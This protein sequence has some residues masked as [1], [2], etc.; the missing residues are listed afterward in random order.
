MVQNLIVPA[1]SHYFTDE[2]VA[3]T[4]QHKLKFAKGGRNMDVNNAG[5]KIL[6]FNKKASR[7]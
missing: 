6:S 5:F 3:V 1:V 4:C 7:I 2:Q